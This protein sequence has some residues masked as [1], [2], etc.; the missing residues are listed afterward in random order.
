[1]I[2]V[3]VRQDNR[4]QGWIFGAKPGH[5]RAKIVGRAVGIQRKAKVEQDS[6]ARGLELDAGAS[7][8]PRWTR[9]RNEPAASVIS[10]WSWR[11]NRVR[12]SL[13]TRRWRFWRRGGH[14]E[15]G[16][17]I[18]KRIRLQAT[19]YLY[20]NERPR[21]CGFSRRKCPCCSGAT[22]P[23]GEAERNRTFG[24]MNVSPGWT[25][26]WRRLQS[27]ASRDRRARTPQ[28]GVRSR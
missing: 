14:C 28:A 6:F 12:P 2:A 1:M 20:S 27:R 7:C 9:P 21:N 18:S 16:G 19:T 23:A 26:D 5:R 15:M 10:G 8:V 25:G 11:P 24:G 4:T 3:S 22:S 17:E 13:A